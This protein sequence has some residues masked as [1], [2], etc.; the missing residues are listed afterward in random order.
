[1]AA[2]RNIRLEIEYD[3]TRYNGWQVQ[4][5]NKNDNSKLRLRTIQETLENTLRKILQEK[6]RIIVSGRTDA[7]V[8]AKAQVANFKTK[9]TIALWKLQKALNALLPKDISISKAE[10]A[11]FNFNS[12]F[13][14]KSKIYRYTILNSPHPSALLRRYTYHCPHQLNIRLMQKEAKTILGRH[15]FKSFQASEKRERSSIRTIKKL[16]IVREQDLIYIYF[17]GN[18]F[19]YNMVRNIVGTLFEIGRGRLARGSLKKILAAKDRKL[20]GPLVAA[21]GLCLIKVE[22]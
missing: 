4:R 16:S 19:L 9:S 7:G 2:G 6:I 15:D 5:R 11:S 20:A 13:D 14:A 8:H 1:M 17:I 3:G 22:Y 18:G 21:R 12:R 10:D